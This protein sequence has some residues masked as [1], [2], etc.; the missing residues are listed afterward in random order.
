M[1][2]VM[3]SRCAGSNAARTCRTRS[4]ELSK[5]SRAGRCSSSATMVTSAPHRRSSSALRAATAPPPTI[6]VG[7]PWTRRNIGRCSMNRLDAKSAPGECR[8]RTRARVQAALARFR[9]LPPPAA[10]AIRLAR[11]HGTCARGAAYAGKLPVMQHVVRELA[12]ADVTPHLLLGPIEQ[13]THLVKA[14]LRVPFYRNALRT[15]PGL[16][17]AH[18]RHPCSVTGDELTER[19]DFADVAAGSARLSAA[20]E[21]V[22]ALA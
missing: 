5:S 1:T 10:G 4:C 6:S 19:Q 18:A 15:H 22:G 12:R 9:V 2:R 21:A 11:L 7:R 3:P 20:E 13:G 8:R 14:V 17:A 16:L